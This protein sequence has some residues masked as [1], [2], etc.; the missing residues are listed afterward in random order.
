MFRYMAI[1]SM[2]KGRALKTHI[3]SNKSLQ[4]ELTDLRDDYSPCNS[5]SVSL[6]LTGHHS[7]ICLL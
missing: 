4:L 1:V 7:L 6:M 2:A 3:G 5:V